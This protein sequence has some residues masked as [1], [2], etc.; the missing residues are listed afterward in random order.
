LRTRENVLRLIDPAVLVRAL[1]NDRAASAASEPGRERLRRLCPDDQL[2]CRRAA[3]EP[4]RRLAVDYGVAHT[5]LGRYFARPEVA[6]QL[7]E[8]RRRS[9]AVAAGEAGAG[10]AAGGSVA[11]RRRYRRL[12]GADLQ[13]IADWHVR[14]ASDAMIASKL[15]CERS[16]VRRARKRPASVRLITAAWARQAKRAE[17]ERERADRH[18]RREA[19]LARA[20]QAAAETAPVGTT[21]AEATSAIP[22]TEFESSDGLVRLKSPDG[23]IHA[24]REKAKVDALLAQ[25]WRRA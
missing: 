13:L 3:G 10:E 9:P 6:R 25:G 23:T 24:W 8:L 14:G 21:L 1:E 17:A 11:G 4:L 19:E 20:E 2:L 5:T 16:T 18:R 15:G 22:E 7:R 12:T